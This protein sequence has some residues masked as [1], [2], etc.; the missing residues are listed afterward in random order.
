MNTDTKRHID[1]ARQ[2]LVGVVPN[3]TSQIDQITNALIYKFMDDMDQAAIKAG[4][5]PSF[6]VG[7]LEH[8]AWTRLMDA[9]MGNQERMNLYSEAL[10]KF[11]QAKQLPELFRGIFKSA[12]LPYRS[13]ETLGLFLKEIDYFDYS[14]P[15]ELGNAYEY[16]LSIM[17]SQGDAGQ[18]RTPRHIIDFIV[19]VVNPTKDDKVLDPACGTGGFL[20]SSYKHILEQHDG[21]DDLKKKEKPLT[22]DERKKLMANFEGYDID[23]TMVRIAQVNMYLH[24]F[25]NP[26]IFQ[27]D[28]LSSDE[29]WNDKFDV[30][31]ANPPFMSPKGGIKPHSKFSVPSSR[32]EVLFVDYIMNHLRPKG[33]AGIIVPEGII[34]RNDEGYR[35]LRKNLVEDGLYAVVSMHNSLFKG[36]KA[37]V[38]TSILLFDN[39]I[40]KQQ[41]E[42]LF[43]KI[44]NDGYALGATRRALC[45]ENG[46][47]PEWCPK[48]SDMPNVKDILNKWNT[49]EKVENKLAVYVEKSKIA[50]NGDYNL[51]GDRY[52]ITT[53]YTNA[54]WPMVELGEVAEILKGSAITKKDTKLGNIPVIA[55]GQEPAY[56]H[57]ESNR[58]GEV[59]TVSASGAYA[60]FVNYFTIPI[61]ASDCSTIQTKDEAIA[62][63]K[64]LYTVLKAK[65]EDIYGFQ[66]GGAQPH[67]YPK[68]LRI[69]QIPLPPLEIQEQ[70]VKELDSY[71]GIIAGAKQI[72][73]SWKPRIDIDPEWEKVKLG[74]ILSFIGSGATPLGGQEVYQT[75]GILFIRSQ[76][77]LLGECDFSDAV[78]ISDDVYEQMRRS[79]VQ[80]NDVLLNITGASIGRCAV[81]IE[82]RKANVNQHVTILRCDKK[83]LPLFLMNIILGKTVQDNIWAVQGG[84]SRQALNYQQIRLF[85]IP[86]PP[87]TTQKQIVTKIEDERKIIEANKKLIGIYDQKTKE[88]IA[89]L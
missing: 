41:T 52:R 49:G 50:E 58:N 60:G 22:P 59:I 86:L 80:K 53:D 25:K 87:L 77:V 21:K 7:D 51:S 29:R 47:K 76:N 85:D 82:D 20:V 16:L 71:A 13:P 4:G 45:N 73:E 56:Y 66:Q 23:P 1:S 62:S 30:I 2:V 32:S 10:I 48:H 33:R 18:F 9:R 11:S 81:Y 70:I 63:T 88:V 36:S 27:Y 3:P 8:Y 84:A 38:K 19:D 83:I 37:G 89:K 65:Q 15:E 46:N 5:D 31:L 35:Q 28:S 55:G 42:I 72:A 78:F 17:S 54:K 64:Y 34:F 75:E 40:T 79:K 68:D 24:Q 14:H 69:I 6:F 26:K 61:F 57:N 44:E 74:D 67:V 43:V 39:E 12:F